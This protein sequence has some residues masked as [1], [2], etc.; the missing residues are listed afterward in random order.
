MW[1]VGSR[2]MVDRGEPAV[3][4]A[5]L[6]VPLAGQ[7]VATGDRWEPLRL[8]DSVVVADDAAWSYFAHFQAEGR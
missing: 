5:G 3:D 7:L 2:V 1:W 6:V 4:A 8:L